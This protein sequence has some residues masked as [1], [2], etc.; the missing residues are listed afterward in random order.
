MQI[1]SK[2]ICKASDVAD[3]CAVFLT[4]ILLALLTAIITAQII[5][6]EFFT[7][8]SWSEEAS[9]YLLVWLTIIGATCVQKRSGHISVTVIHD[10]VP[11]NVRDVLQ[12]S[13]QLLCIIVFVVMSYF[14][15]TYMGMMG[16]QLSPAMRIPMRYIYLVIP[17]G[18]VI[19]ILHSFSWLMKFFE[20]NED[21]K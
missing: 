16:E 3:Q 18:G 15:I 19:L 12:V 14:G 6:R 10:I 5:S 8:L 2:F 7:A 11:K 17:F 21:K 9:R 4:V 20:K 13:A 1:I